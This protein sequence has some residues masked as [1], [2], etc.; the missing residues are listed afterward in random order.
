VLKVLILP[1]REKVTAAHQVV[2]RVLL[3]H[4]SNSFFRVSGNNIR[5][6]REIGWDRMDWIDLAQ[7]R[8][9][10]RALVKTAMGSS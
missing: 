8:Y 1:N 9:Q 3:A 4:H 7:D 2:G 6:L 10:W 5:D